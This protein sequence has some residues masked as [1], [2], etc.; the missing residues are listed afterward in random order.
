MKFIEIILSLNFYFIN[1]CC[2]INKMKKETTPMH[3]YNLHYLTV[4]QQESTIR[5]VK[6]NFT[7]LLDY[8][9]DGR[10]MRL[11]LSTP[12]QRLWVEWLTCISD[13][14]EEANKNSD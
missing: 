13:I 4:I 6:K 8:I 7:I 9:D 3:R 11:I 2:D 14:I 5:R 12:S 10:T 1:F